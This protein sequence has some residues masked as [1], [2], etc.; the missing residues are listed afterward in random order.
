MGRRKKSAVETPNLSAHWVRT[1]TF[2]I[3][4]RHVQ[5]GTE[6][7]IQGERGRFKFIQHIYNPKIDV[8][9]IDVVGGKKGVKEV[10]SFRPTQ[11]KRVH[12]KNKLRPDKT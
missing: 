5:R 8:E 4:G 6:L 12:Y 2:T 10:R 7:S 9:W 3:N 1:E 11:V